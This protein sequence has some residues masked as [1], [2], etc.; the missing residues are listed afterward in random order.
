V[1][2]LCGLLVVVARRAKPVDGAASLFLIPLLLLFFLLIVP[3]T[4]P[5]GPSE[6]LTYVIRETYQP[7]N[8]LAAVMMQGTP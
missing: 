2:W 4:V 5:G 6:R 7:M 1:G 8:R 3:V